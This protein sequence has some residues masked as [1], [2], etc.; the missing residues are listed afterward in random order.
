MMSGLAKRAPPAKHIFFLFV[1]KSKHFITKRNLW[2][3]TLPF[4]KYIY[5]QFVNRTKNKLFIP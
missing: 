4:R 1:K 5:T 2:G 3:F